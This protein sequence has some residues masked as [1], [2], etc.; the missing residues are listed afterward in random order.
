[1]ENGC[2][3]Q[4]RP[5]SHLRRVCLLGLPPYLPLDWVVSAKMKV[6]AILAVV[7]GLACEAAAQRYVYRYR[8]VERGCINGQCPAPAPVTIKPAGDGTLPLRGDGTWPLSGDGSLPL[9]AEKANPT[10]EAQK[11]AEYKVR[12]MV[13]VGRCFHVGGWIGRFEGVGMSSGGGTIPTCTPCG[14]SHCEG[15]GRCGKP[16]GDAKA[17]SVRTRSWYRVRIW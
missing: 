5:R 14:R 1:M 10:T 11:W 2:R 7:C 13:R 3:F 16:R 8:V 9:K 12:K 15:C 6:L 4:F 17:Y